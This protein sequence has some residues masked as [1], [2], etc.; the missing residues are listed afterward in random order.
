MKAWLKTHFVKLSNH[1]T[2]GEQLK[3]SYIWLIK[4]IKRLGDLLRYSWNGASIRSTNDT[5]NFKQVIILLRNVPSLDWQSHYYDFSICSQFKF[6][7]KVRTVI[8]KRMCEGTNIFY[9]IQVQFLIFF[10]TS[11]SLQMMMMKLPISSLLEGRYDF[12]DS[13]V[14]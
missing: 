7:W 1:L 2:H 4:E 6:F 12:F 10:D 11:S 9:I 5:L 8:R 14:C 13:L 3:T